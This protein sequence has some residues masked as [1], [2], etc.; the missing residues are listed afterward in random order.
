MTAVRPLSL[1]IVL[2]AGLFVMKSVSLGFGAADLFSA[3]AQAAE[4]EPGEDDAPGNDTPQPDAPDSGVEGGAER[5]APQPQS[6]AAPAPRPAA[7]V[8]RLGDTRSELELLNALSD[9]RRQLDRRADELDTREQ[10]L[11]VAEQRVEGRI[12]ALQ[13]L[14]G[15]VQALLGHLDERREEEISRIVAVYSALEPDAAALIFVSLDDVTRLLVA[16]RLSERKLAGILAE[17]APEQAAALTVQ[18]HARAVPPDTVGQ[19]R[20]R[21]D[22]TAT[23]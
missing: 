21:L 10:L 23:R 14:R 2:L 9:R 20:E 16:E 12:D 3:R 15:E 8:D 17:M 18:M 19:M 6:A 1:I 13:T 5:A 7:P 22:E 4:T 11:D